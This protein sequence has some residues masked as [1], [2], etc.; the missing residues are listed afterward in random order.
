LTYG[1]AVDYG[2]GNRTKGLLVPETPVIGKVEECL[3]VITLR[4]SSD[5]DGQIAIRAELF[6][7]IPLKDGE[8]DIDR[9]STAQKVAITMLNAAT[10]GGQVQT[11]VVG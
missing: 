10:K 7:T 1:Y 2:P 5:G 4:D 6:P 8:P 3:V 11:E 9:C